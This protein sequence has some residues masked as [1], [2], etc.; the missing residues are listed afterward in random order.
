MSDLIFKLLP[1]TANRMPDERAVP[2]VARVLLVAV[3]NTV[4]LALYCAAPLLAWRLVVG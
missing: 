3:A 1:V 2:F 4:V